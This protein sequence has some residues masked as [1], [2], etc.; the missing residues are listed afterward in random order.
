MKNTTTASRILISIQAIWAFIALFITAQMTSSPTH[1]IIAFISVCVPIWSFYGMLWVFDLKRFPLWTCFVF[2]LPYGI[3]ILPFLI[4][5]QNY[6]D[7]Y[8]PFLMFITPI[9]FL[10][11]RHIQ[12]YNYPQKTIKTELVENISSCK[13]FL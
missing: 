1:T 13:N 7:D 11:F 8:M 9:A 4:D 10:I 12:N 3:S 5:R 2:L 6:D